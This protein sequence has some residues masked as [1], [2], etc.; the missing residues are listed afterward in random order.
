ML[1]SDG[2]WSI[3]A[4]RPICLLLLAGIVVLLAMPIV[5]GLTQTIVPPKPSAERS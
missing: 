3:Y 1:M 5:R 4:M 2:K